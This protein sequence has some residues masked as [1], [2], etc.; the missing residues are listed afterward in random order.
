M[1]LVL[2]ILSNI[3]SDIRFSGSAPRSLYIQR[4]Q[5]TLDCRTINEV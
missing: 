1:L 2:S 3:S 5:K 4:E